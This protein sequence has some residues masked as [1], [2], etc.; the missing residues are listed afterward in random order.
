MKSPVLTMNT[1]QTDKKPFKCEICN[2]TFSKSD[3][4]NRHKTVH[5]MKPY[6][7]NTCRKAFLTKSD[8]TVHKRIHTGSHTI[9]IHVTKLL[10]EM[11]S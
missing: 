2:M 5:G 6:S 3:S 9:V 7:C 4:F 11:L 1:H 10:L 8:L